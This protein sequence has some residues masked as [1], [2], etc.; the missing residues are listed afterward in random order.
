M[1]IPC[2]SF[3]INKNIVLAANQAKALVKEKEIVVIPTKTVPQGITAIISFMPDAD[4]KANE[5]AMLE[6]IQQVKTGQVTYAVRDTHVMI[7]KSM[8]EISWES[9]TREFLRLELK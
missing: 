2:L 8:K 4:A 5:E 7:R 9:A 6:G 1:R 3:R